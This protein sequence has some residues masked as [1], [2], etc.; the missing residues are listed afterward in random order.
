MVKGHGVLAPL[1]QE[2]AAF[3][4]ALVAVGMVLGLAGR[5]GRLEPVTLL[6]VG[7]IVN[8]VNGSV[9]L[10]I[11]AL[12]RCSAGQWRANGVSG[13]S[14]SG[15]HRRPALG[16]V[17]VDRIGLVRADVFMRATQRGRVG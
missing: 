14:D 17:G 1:S 5:R 3:I 4:G 8:A 16:G 11:N 7:V 15:D 6:L 10:L 13:R 9:F 2:T 12:V